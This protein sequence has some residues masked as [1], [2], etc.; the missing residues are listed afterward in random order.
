MAATSLE[1]GETKV[2]YLGTESRVDENVLG[3]R[4]NETRKIENG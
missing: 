3:L 2:S 1:M 4:T